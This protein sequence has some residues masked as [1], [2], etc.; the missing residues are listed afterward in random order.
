[1]PKNNQ[2]LITSY[3]DFS[4]ELAVTVSPQSTGVRL[5]LIPAGTVSVPIGTEVFLPPA[6]VDGGSDEPSDGDTYTI[7][8]ADGSCNGTAPIIVTPPD[9]T[10]IDGASEFALSLAGGSMTCTFD[11][12]NSNF[13]VELGGQSILAL[14]ELQAGTIAGQVTPTNITPNIAGAILWAASLQPFVVGLFKVEMTFDFT[15]SA[16]DE[17]SVALRIYG[18][19]ISVTGGTAV[20]GGQLNYETSTAVVV[21]AGSGPSAAKASA[22][23]TV[24]ATKQGVL[25]L[26]ALIQCAAVPETPPDV[27]LEPVGIDCF[28]TTGA[29]GTALSALGLNVVITEVA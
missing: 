16:S 19:L 3:Q 4:D 10:T 6:V 8:D 14:N 26:T 27:G 29:N 12:D 28:L 1:M 25:S 24:V 2:Q 15:S 22:T 20:P 21:T 9:G 17:V 13:N 7:V 18:D 11:A 23:V 5:R